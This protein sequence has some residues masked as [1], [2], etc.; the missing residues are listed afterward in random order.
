V[1]AGGEQCSIEL[2]SVDVPGRV[3]LFTF[4]NA[5]RSLTASRWGS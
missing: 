4:G 2:T 3:L 5:I 1:G